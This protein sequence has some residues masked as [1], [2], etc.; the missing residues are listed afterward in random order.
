M[1]NKICL[2]NIC[3]LSEALDSNYRELEFIEYFLAHVRNILNG[4]KL[5]K[6]LLQ[7]G[8]NKTSNLSDWHSLLAELESFYLLHYKLCVNVTAYE[9]D[10]DGQK[11]K[12]EFSATINNQ[13]VYFEVKDKCSEVVQQVP[14]KINRLFDEVEK[15]YHDKYQ[16]VITE[17]EGLRYRDIEGHENMIIIEKAVKERLTT[18]EYY[19]VLERP[20]RSSSTVDIPIGNGRVIVSIRKKDNQ[21]YD[22]PEYFT[23]DGIDDIRNWLFEGGCISRR[24]SK[25]MVPMVKQAEAKG[26][27]YLLCRIPFRPFYDDVK[28]LFSDLT[29]IRS[30][31]AK[32]NDQNL[33][34][35]LSGIILLSSYGSLSDDFFIVDNTNIRSKIKNWF[36]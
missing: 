3:E 20:D 19:K 14:E 26:A 1:G 27:D 21:K 15:K 8:A 25:S 24:T 7:C 34:T 28:P 18:L 22:R 23:P 31:Y 33:G 13:T 36:K 9:P 30:N 2:K 11:K 17:V 5:A 10:V 35:K 16:I 4:N 6:K 12:P 32:S 29:L